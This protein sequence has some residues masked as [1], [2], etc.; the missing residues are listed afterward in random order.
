M[1]SFLRDP[2]TIALILSNLLTIALAVTYNWSLLTIMLIYWSQSV[3]IGIFNVLK[4]LSL[5]EFSTQG[6]RIGNKPVS[7]TKSVK[8][9]T[10]IFFAVHYGFFHFGYLMFMTIGMFAASMFSKFGPVSPQRI[11]VPQIDFT[12]ITITA[13]IFF[14]NHLISF[15]YYKSRT[16][17]TPPNIGKIMFYPYARIIPMH[18]TI[19]LGGLLF[20]TANTIVLVL[21]LLLKTAADV[22]MH[23]IE[24]REE[25][26]PQSF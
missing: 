25:I 20:G 12:A 8:Y 16:E 13:A 17:K 10:A 19:I 14:I 4:I 23:Y 5:K 3:I 9:F 24:H 22:I 1:K 21:F 11:E 18:L 6:V 7:P 2:S 26:Q 15:L